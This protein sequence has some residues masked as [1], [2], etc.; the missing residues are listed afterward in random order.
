[1]RSRPP[2]PARRRRPRA[3]ARQPAERPIDAVSSALPRSA[4]TCYTCLPRR[5][6]ATLAR[7]TKMKLYYAPGACSIGI[8]ALLEEIGKPYQLEP[9][10]LREG[11]QF[12][13]PYNTVSPKAK[14]P[15]LE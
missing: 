4:R 1:R 14:V 2:R 13:A 9:V 15:A 6:A 8:H 5:A 11:A 7:L 10:N 3:P 12:K